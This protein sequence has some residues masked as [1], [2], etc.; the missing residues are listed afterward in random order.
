MY[1]VSVEDE[2]FDVEDDLPDDR[3]PDGNFIKI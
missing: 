3:H 2:S 1:L